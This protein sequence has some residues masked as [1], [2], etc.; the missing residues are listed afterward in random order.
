MHG[1]EQHHQWC[2]NLLA[3]C[4]VTQCQVMLVDIQGH[5]CGSKCVP[6]HCML[7]MICL[8]IPLLVTR[9]ATRTPHT[10]G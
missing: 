2:I 7:G 1:N 4:A 9:G 5:F 8:G 6:E 10:G 3:I